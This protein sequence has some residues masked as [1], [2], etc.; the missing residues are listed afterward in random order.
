MKKRMAYKF[1]L[2]LDDKQKAIIANYGGS[3][4][5]LWNK[6]L[7]INL[8]RLK[9]KQH[10]LYYQ[11]LDFFSKLWKKSEE[12]GFLKECPSQTIQQKLRDLEKAFKDCFDKKQPLKRLPRFKKKGCG[13]SFRYPQGFKVSGNQVFLPKLGWLRFR[14]SRNILGVIKNITIGGNGGN[15]YVSIQVEQEVNKPVHPSKS[16]VGIDVGIAKF[17]TLS[18]G[19]YIEPVNSYKTLRKKLKK[20]QRALSRKKKFSSNWKKAKIVLQKVHSKIANVRRDFLHKSSTAISKNHAMIVMEDLKVANMSKSAKGT[21]D[22]PGNSVKSKSGLNRSILD[23]GW[24][25]FRRQLTY[26]QEWLGGDVLV[27]PPHNTSITCPECAHKSKENRVTQSNFKC[28]ACEYKNNADVVGAINILR[29]GHSR[30]AC[31]KKLPSVVDIGDI[32][33]QAQ[34]SPMVAA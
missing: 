34:E 23:Q 15:W 6:A 17:A 19:E 32:S 11:E 14:K 3:T 25:E 20:A 29:L 13:D 28:R 1:K 16:I 2:K 12:Y 4:R 8:E 18:T 26:K 27:V 10:I 22:E 24:S 7:A 30:L 9:N 31:G 5:F 33:L 21:I